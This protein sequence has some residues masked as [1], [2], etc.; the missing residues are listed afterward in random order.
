MVYSPFLYS[1]K[2][3]R[4]KYVKDFKTLRGDMATYY[5][6]FSLGT[7]LDPVVSVPYVDAFGLGM[8]NQTPLI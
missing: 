1:F 2:T 5:D 6:L 3:G 7:H 4:Y 8:L